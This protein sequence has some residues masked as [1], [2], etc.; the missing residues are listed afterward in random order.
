MEYVPILTKIFTLMSV[1]FILAMIFTPILTYFLYKYR[2]SQQIRDAAL[3]GEKAVVFHSLH[4][5]KRDTPT[6]GGLLVWVTVLFVSFLFYFIS[7]Y[8]KNKFLENLNFL[9]RKETWLPL[10]TLVAAGILGFFDDLLNVLGINKVKGINVK[11]KFI[12]QILIGIVGG[13]WFYY[14]L[15]WSFIHIPGGNLF[16]LPYNINIGWLYIPLFILVIVSTANAVNITDGLDGLS[17]GIL[18]TAFGAFSVIAFVSNKMDLAAFCAVIIG[19]LIA[20]LWFN[21]YPA[22]FF[23]GDTGALSLGAT[24]GVVALFLNSVLVLPIIGFILVIETLSSIIQIASKKFRGKKVF[25]VAPLHHHFEAI[26]WPEPKVVMRFW[27]ISAIFAVIGMI[28]GIIG[29]G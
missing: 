23:M 22:R 18:I 17:G 26:G 10:F 19:A 21:I 27:I 5:K 8:S 7:L 2:I 20:F 13:L 15:D 6:M 9:S 24:L 3:S 25:K 16:G 28:I 12:W 4:I 1:S 11:Y 29:R 14:K